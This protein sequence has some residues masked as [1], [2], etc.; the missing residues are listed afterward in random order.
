MEAKLLGYLGQTLVNVPAMFLVLYVCWLLANKTLA[1]LKEKLKDTSDRL[2]RLEGLQSDCKEECAN[3]FKETNA[4]I[5]R[6]NIDILNGINELKISLAKMEGA[7]TL[8]K[9]MVNE[10]RS[11]Q[12]AD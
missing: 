7:K 10:L 9:D 11:I 4:D 3:R 1:D 2:V 6:L 12:R 8:A 5:V